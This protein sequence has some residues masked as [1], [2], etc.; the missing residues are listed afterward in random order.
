MLKVDPVKATFGGK[1]TLSDLDPPNSYRIPGKNSGGI[2]S[3]AKGSATVN[4]AEASADVTILSHKVD[5]KV[6]GKLAQLGARL[7][8]S[9]A[10]TGS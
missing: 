6:G 4:L 10:K 9:T 5:G 3:F 2:A 7:I 1:V 8:D